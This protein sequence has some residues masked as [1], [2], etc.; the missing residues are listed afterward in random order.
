MIC[1]IYQREYCLKRKYTYKPIVW[2][3]DSSI[4]YLKAHNYPNYWYFT[5]WVEIIHSFNPESF[6]ELKWLEKLFF[7]HTQCPR[8]LLS[9]EFILHEDDV[10]THSISDISIIQYKLVD[11]KGNIVNIK[12]YIEKYLIKRQYDIEQNKKSIEYRP[13]FRYYFRHPQTTNE[14]KQFPSKDDI[15]EWEKYGYKIKHRQKRNPSNL[16]DLYDDIYIHTD[17]C[18]KSHTKQSRQYLR[19]LKGKQKRIH[20]ALLKLYKK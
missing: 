14:K 3:S 1:K 15:N 20:G 2:G 18:W 7:G 4:N 5:P 17:K 19:N 11:E 16:A 13:P 8:Y 12:P 6:D 10:P 9:L